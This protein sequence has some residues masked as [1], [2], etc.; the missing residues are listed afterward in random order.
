MRRQDLPFHL[1]GGSALGRSSFTTYLIRENGLEA[2]GFEEWFFYPGMLFKDTK[3]WW[4][5]RGDRK[6]PHEGLDLCFYRDRH[7]SILPL[8]EK[9]KIPVLYDGIV[10]KVMDDFIGRS[11][12]VEHPGYR[13]GLRRLVT[14]YGHTIPLPTLQP[15]RIV[16]AGEPLAILA[17]TDKSKNELP[18]HLHLSIAWVGPEISF[19][20]LHWKA[21]ETLQDLT[22]IDPL[23]LI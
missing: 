3:K 8:G 17:P 9:T 14:L 11:V 23:P 2:F 21:M 18:P 20:Q 7:G 5:D 6:R 1:L 15:D 12:V 22:W 16:R 10:V 13:K 4:G 19:D